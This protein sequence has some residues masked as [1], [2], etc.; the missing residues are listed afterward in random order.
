MLYV[1]IDRRRKLHATVLLRAL[2]Y[3]TEELLN[4]YYD[5][6][7][8][9]LEPNKKYAK[10]VEYD[11]LPGQRASRDIRHPDTREVLVKKNRKFTKLAIKKL[12]DSN[13]ER[14]SVEVTDLVGKVAASDIID[15]RGPD[16]D[17]GVVLLDRQEPLGGNH[18]AHERELLGAGGLQA[19]ERVHR[20]TA[21][22][23]HRVDHID[24][25]VRQ[26]GR[27]ALVIVHGAVLLLVAVDPH[28]PDARAGKQSQEPVD[29]AQPGSQHR[30]DRDF[31]GKAAAGCGLERRL[32]IDGG[33]GEVARG[34]DGEDRRGL[35]QR[36][37]K[38]PVTR[39]LVA[40]DGEPVG[41]HRVVDDDEA[42]WHVA[43]IAS[44]ASVRSQPQHRAEGQRPRSGR[45]PRPRARLGRSRRGGDP[46]AR[47]LLRRRPRA[48]QAPRAGARR[49]RADPVPPRAS[50]RGPH[51][52]VPARAGAGRGS[53]PRGARR[54]AR[55][56]RGGRQ[57][58]AA[59][60]LGERTIHL[61]EV[62]AL[63][64]FV[65]LEAVAEEG[66]DLSEEH[67]KVERL[68]EQLGIADADLV[69]S[70]YSDLL[71]DAPET[72]LRAAEAAMKNAHAPYSRFPVGAALRASGGGIYTGANVENAAYPQGQCAEASAIGALVAA[73]ARTITSVAVVAE[74]EDICPPCGGCRQRLSEFA[75]PDTPVHLGRPGGP[76]QT[77]ALRELLPY[78]FD[79]DPP[80]T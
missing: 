15:R 7:T 21:G 41:E 12:K 64:S 17:L 1:R 14:L 80:K 71:L 40:H 10:S 25:G 68:R 77:L 49:R 72:L 38:L 45:H 55:D 44:R 2:G 56:A 79:L 16:R 3:S 29:H 6:E 36:L 58:P 74:R 30:H 57:A 53:A 52:R 27:E 76:R 23:E 5:T 32:D 11:L 62:E 48:A 39:A 35:E 13:V 4:Y 8:I 54:R 47:H 73:G 43:T 28:M 26:A 60:P 22:R 33:R 50:G 42:L 19:V 34:L 69:A 75:G 66:S 67:S 31:P 9:Y 37:A 24:E 51:E 70:S 18:E 63:G 20:A 59:A 61:D 65:E 46:P 78:A